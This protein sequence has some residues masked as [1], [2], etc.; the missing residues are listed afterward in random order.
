MQVMPLNPDAEEFPEEMWQRV[1]KAFEEHGERDLYLREYN[2]VSVPGHCIARFV[3]LTSL[4]LSFN[5]ISCLPDE[6]GGLSLLTILLLNNNKLVELPSLGRLKKLEILHLQNNLLSWVPEELCSLPCLRH[7]KTLMNKFD[8]ASSNVVD[9]EFPELQ[10]M[11]STVLLRNGVAL[12]DFFDRQVKVCVTCGLRFVGFGI[13]MLKRAVLGEGSGDGGQVM[14]RSVV[15]SFSCF[16]S[17]G[18]RKFSRQGG[19]VDEMIRISQNVYSM[20]RVLSLV[21]NAPIPDKP[22][23]V[24]LLNC[25]G[26][27][28]KNTPL[29]I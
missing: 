17:E 24:A 25:K 12:P 29:L 18:L 7:V 22:N 28:K 27:K 10:D 20:N 21:R 4:D 11:C 26:N 15:C 1:A 3:M 14:V 9:Y 2:V 23:R 5:R 6:I 13:Q 8:F 16:Q 19:G